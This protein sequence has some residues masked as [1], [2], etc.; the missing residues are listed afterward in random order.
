MSTK[1]NDR[2]STA[3]KKTISTISSRRP[4]LEAEKTKTKKK[5]ANAESTRR[6]IAEN[7]KLD[8]KK[9]LKKIN[10]PDRETKMKQ[11]LTKK[12]SIATKKPAQISKEKPS[13]NLK[14]APKP[15]E[16][17]KT[18][19]PKFTKSIN[20]SANPNP[21][22][23]RPTTAT[24]LRGTVLNI[25]K[26]GP[27]NP[28][29]DQTKSPSP[30]SDSSEGKYEDDFESY[31]SD[32]EDYSSSSSNG[33]L[34]AS[35]PSSSPL[36]SYS[37]EPT[38]F[39]KHS[40]NGL[41]L[42]SGSE[43]DKTLDS[44][45][46]EMPG[47]KHRPML[48]NIKE[49]IERENANVLSPPGNYA[50][51]SDE[52]FEDQKSFQFVNF[53]DAQMKNRR[54]NSMQMRRKRGEEILSMV[55]LDYYSFTLLDIASISYEKYVKLYGARN[56]LQVSTQTGE[57]DVDEEVQTEETSMLDKATQK[58]EVFGSHN[59][60]DNA[61]KCVNYTNL[62]KFLSSA[63]EVVLKINE[64]SNSVEYK[65]QSETF[66]KSLVNFKAKTDIFDDSYVT[67]IH[68]PLHQND[69]FVTVHSKRDGSSLTASWNFNHDEPD[70]VI[71]SYGNISSCS[72]GFNYQELIFTGLEDG[73]I[74]VWKGSRRLLKGEYIIRVPLFTTG[75]NSG[76]HN[77]IIGLNFLDDVS[78]KGNVQRANE[79]CSLD[80]TGEI[81]LWTIISKCSGNENDVDYNKITLLKNSTISLINLCP[82]L[83]DLLC[84]RFCSSP[85]N[86]H[87]L[88]I[89]TNYGS[90]IHYTIKAGMNKAKTYLTEVQS[91]P[92][93]L[94]CCPFSSEYFLVG[95]ENGDISLF[96]RSSEK[97]LMILSD[98]D[99]SRIS[100]I[101]SIEW[102]RDKSTVIY[103]KD[104]DNN[105]NVWDLDESDMVPLYTIPYKENIACM[106]IIKDEKT[107]KLFMLIGT[108][109]G[110]LHLHQLNEGR[111][112]PTSELHTQSIKTFFS[113]VKRL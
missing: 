96:S 28:P 99:K 90:V 8:Q 15:A 4:L 23:E 68:F 75:I 19:L 35:S 44:G 105:I 67:C 47:F 79:L 3:P 16:N 29:T 78:N 97:P 54:R 74:L 109:E 5:P 80:E 2:G 112:Q 18:S 53:A 57:D 86:P 25:N 81:I 9:D 65:S 33:L 39:G 101:E 66:S 21:Q 93:S 103:S 31:E 62:N 36:S 88:F 45:H 55:K 72:T 94:E 1:K 38:S 108:K 50:S 85:L 110:N 32:F 30:K 12:T 27:D 76:H 58:P 64:E 60:N 41:V 13:L 98:K 111:N 24:L 10:N 14:K 26:I 83:N 17:S 77:K 92:K 95:Y 11:E 73:A 84:T 113:Y 48:D 89:A 71:V 46:F 59:E 56:R 40:T 6:K 42:S 100:A 106:R 82:D 63:L 52:G 7:D 43:D 69:K 87:Y 102:S 104:D 91:V 22:P 51:F 37:D 34:L 107:Q 49:A 70:I 20:S 61:E